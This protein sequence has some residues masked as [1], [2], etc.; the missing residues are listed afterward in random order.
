[1][2]LSAD[3]RRRLIDMELALAADPELSRLAA[4]IHIAAD[5]QKPGNLLWRLLC[6]RS[7]RPQA[8]RPVRR[9]RPLR[10]SPKVVGRICIALVLLS[11]I[12]FEFVLCYGRG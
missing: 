6:W 10:P 7:R 12:V 8:F 9:M 3:E 11:A 1:M 5:R 4:R 2:G